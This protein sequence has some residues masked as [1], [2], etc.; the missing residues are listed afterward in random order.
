[1][2]MLKYILLV[3]DDEIANHL[4]SLLI[5]DLNIAEHIEVATDGEEAL[6]II[7]ARLQEEHSDDFSMLALVDINMP[8]MDAFEFLNEYENMATDFSPKIHIVLLS[9]SSNP[10]DK[11]KAEKYNISGYMIKPLTEEKLMDIVK[12][13]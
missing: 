7:D 6:E 2:E 9:S 4:H 12:A 10:K 5:S 3:D 8:G 1:M 11:E 13:M